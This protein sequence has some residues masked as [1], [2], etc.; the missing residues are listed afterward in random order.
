[1]SPHFSDSLSH[2]QH[3]TFIVE[4][5]PNDLDGT[6][7]PGNYLTGADLDPRVAPLG[8]FF[9]RDP[10]DDRRDVGPGRQ[11]RA[12]GA[13]L[14]RGEQNRAAQV[15]ILLGLDRLANGVHFSM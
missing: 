6:R 7:K 2:V 11:R 4:R 12:H 5:V 3:L 13:R 9:N 1:M 8:Y 14:A 15:G 10:I